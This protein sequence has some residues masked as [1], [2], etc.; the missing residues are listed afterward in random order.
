MN[1]ISNWTDNALQQQKIVLTDGSIVTLQL[2]F[3]PQQ[4][5]WFLQEV[6]W[7]TFVVQEIRITNNVNLLLSWRNL[8]PFGL[9]CITAGG[10]EPSLPQDFSSGASQ[11]Y[12]LTPTDLATFNA[13]LATAVST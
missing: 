11:L 5:G 8:I 6:A 12:V 2:Y 10:R 9:A 13:T 1:L 7:G 3:R 4:Q